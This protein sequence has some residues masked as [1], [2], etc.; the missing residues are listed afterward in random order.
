MRF[1]GGMVNGSA[2]V[3]ANARLWSVHEQIPNDACRLGSSRYSLK[4]QI[5]RW[6][7]GMVWAETRLGQSNLLGQFAYR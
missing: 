6:F 2:A 4:E 3:A 1:V 5:W 7:R